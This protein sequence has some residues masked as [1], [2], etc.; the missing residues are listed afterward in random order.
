MLPSQVLLLHAF[1]DHS[2]ASLLLRRL[3]R[4]LCSPEDK[5]CAA[6]SVRLMRAHTIYITV[7]S[8]VAHF[9]IG[10]CTHMSVQEIARLHLK[11][12]AGAGLTKQAAAAAA[13]ICIAGFASPVMRVLDL[14][15]AAP[16]FASN[17][18]GSVSLPLMLDTLAVTSARADKSRDGYHYFEQPSEVTDAAGAEVCMGNSVARVVARLVLKSL[19][20]QT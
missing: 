7:A 14:S 15:V 19:C 20:P 16:T 8:D 3:E 6:A 1:P 10:L 9:I 12:A 13:F 2:S 4:L 11:N 5:V 18:E 17:S